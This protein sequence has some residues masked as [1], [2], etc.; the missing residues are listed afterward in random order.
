MT[1]FFGHAAMLQKSG[2]SSV[3][4]EMRAHG[5]SEGDV[6]CLGLKEY[7]DAQ[8]AVQHIKAQNSEMPIVIYGLSM[9]AGTAINAIGETPKID[10]LISLSAFS[11]WPDV[12]ADN[13]ELMGLPRFL[14]DI[15]KP[16]V[17]LY[18]GAKYGFDRLHISPVNEIRKLNG[19]PALLM[20]SRGDTQVPFGSFETLTKAAPQVQTFV[21]DGDYHAICDDHFLHPE[22]DAEYAEAVLGFL[23][24]RF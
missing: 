6:I 24:T 1:A 3:L 22:Q 10:A 23:N 18:M 7:M 17:W 12:F 9:G 13:M 2:Y 15:E 19:R 14:C 11:S 8:A 20:H 21:R 5:A 4:V 16:F